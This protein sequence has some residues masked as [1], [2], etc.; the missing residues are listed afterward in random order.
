MN[1]HWTD[2]AIEHL[3]CIYE[4]IAVNSPAYAKGMVDR[5]THRS[6]QIADSPLSG[7]MVPEY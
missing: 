7:R 3:A 1:V 2:N 5:I 4:Y 6:S